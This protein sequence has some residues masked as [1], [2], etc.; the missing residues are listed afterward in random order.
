MKSLA[1][2]V[3][4]GRTITALAAIVEVLNRDDNAR[5][6]V[7]VPAALLHQWADEVARFAPGLTVAF[8]GGKGDGWF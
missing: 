2:D 7:T 5:A 4:L 6:M 1:D 3:G 8:A